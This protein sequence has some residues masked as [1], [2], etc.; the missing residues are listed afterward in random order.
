MMTNSH[1]IAILL[2]LAVGATAVACTI[3]IRALAAIATVNFIRRERK[4][5]ASA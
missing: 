3:F 4:L 2:P 1:R 5:G